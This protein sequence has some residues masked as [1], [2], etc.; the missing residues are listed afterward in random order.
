MALSKN[1]KYD[2][3]LQYRKIFEIG[4]IISISLLIIAFKFFPRFEEDSAVIEVVN[5]V[6]NVEDIV[7]T[8]Q[9][10][11]PPPPP[12]PPIPI[13]APSDDVLDEIEI[14]DLEMDIDE[15]ISTPPPPVVE[16]EEEEE[17]AVFFVA[18]QNQ[19]QI[20]GGL[21]ALQ[22]HLEYPELAIRAG[23]SGTVI[24]NAFVDEKGKVHKLVVLKGIGAG[25]DEAALKAVSMV[26][27]EPGKQRG[28]AVRCQV[29]IPVRF[30]IRN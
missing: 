9:E 20:I 19:P 27:F 8:K 14:D 7:Q 15:I 11:K 28:R 23:V 22:Q 13:E 21:A 5:E 30:V 25:C 2:L 6:V 3:K 12:K 24:V 29:S 26:K 17:E 10:Q 4:L 16:E 18:V 1:P